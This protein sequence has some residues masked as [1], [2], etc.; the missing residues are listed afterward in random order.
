LRTRPLN[1]RRPRRIHE[2]FLENLENTLFKNKLPSLSSLILL[3][4]LMTGCQDIFQHQESTNTAA[5]SGPGS[6]PSPSELSELTP[7][8]ETYSALVRHSF[9]EVGQDFDPFVTKNG[10][11][12][13]YASTCHSPKSDIYLK[14]ADSR[15]I[16][17]VTHTPNASE[18]QPQISPDGQTIIFASD[19]EGQWNIYETSFVQRGALV[20]EVVRNGRV[21]EQP[22]YSPDGKKVAY[23]TWMP[24]KGQWYIAVTDRASQQEVIYGPGLFPK[25]SPDGKKL[26]F[27]R[28]RTRAPQWYSIWIL[29]LES[30]NPSEIISSSSWAAV[31]PS[32]SP[33]SKKIIFAAINKSIQ[34]KGAYVGDDIYTIWADGT[35][36]VRLTNDDAP[37]WN[38]VWANNGRVFF[39]S[40][41]NGQQNIWSVSPKN[42]DTFHPDTIESMAPK[43]LDNL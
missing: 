9:S 34:S 1:P 2:K 32:W 38:P 14:K 22:C 21:N 16:E 28:P 26:L 33:D 13:L 35:H 29:D 10:E 37:D 3:P 8:G 40:L 4:L 27:Q 12:V 36:L 15:V 11:S 31:T 20:L 7:M 23:A 42:L 5:D 30:E 18:K 25:F 39:V 24:R 43:S 17:Q 6:I 19:R 41:R